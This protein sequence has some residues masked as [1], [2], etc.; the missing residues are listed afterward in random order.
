MNAW[1]QLRRLL[2]EWRERHRW[3]TVCSSQWK[4]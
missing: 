1:R 4:F 2:Q 3:D